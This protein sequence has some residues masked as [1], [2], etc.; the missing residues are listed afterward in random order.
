MSISEILLSAVFSS[1]VSIIITGLVVK[2]WY[3][4]VRK[5]KGVFGKDL[6]NLSVIARINLNESMDRDVLKDKLHRIIDKA[7]GGRPKELL[8][9]KEDCRYNLLLTGVCD[10]NDEGDEEEDVGNICSFHI[11]FDFRKISVKN[12]P[13]RLSSVMDIRRDLAGLWDIADITSISSTVTIEFKGSTWLTHATPGTKLREITLKNN[14]EKTVWISGGKME[15][16]SS[17]TTS[18]NKAVHNAV[19]FILYGPS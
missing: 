10:D 18:D 14:A 4:I 15:I 1:I 13:D 17:L 6:T 7:P 16:E 2:N 8:V 19:L 12:I 9:V 5:F 11:R 3:Y